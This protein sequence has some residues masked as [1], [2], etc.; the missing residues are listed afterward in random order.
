MA[1]NKSTL[2]LGD[3]Y[4]EIAVVLVTVIALAAGWFYKSSV[5]NRSV[6]FATNAV[7]GEAP[8][9][10]R[11][12]T[13]E[14]DEVLRVADFASGGFS[15]T[16]VVR[17]IPVPA[18][19]TAS[20]VASLLSLEYGQN[21]TAFRVLEQGDVHVFGKA[22][23][24]ISYVYVESNPDLTHASLPTVVRG[25][26]YIFLNGDRAVVATFRASEDNFDIDLVRFHLFLR[27]LR[28]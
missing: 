19:A 5:E 25:V 20:Q 11:Q 21:L 7:S 16:Y 17:N 3:R 14:G 1:T 9:G 10:W 28:F 23:Y 15:T 6:P 4:A 22:A 18:D 2:S 27:S 13:P 24:E 26:D 12:F 8:A